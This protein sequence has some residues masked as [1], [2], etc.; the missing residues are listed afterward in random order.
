MLTLSSLCLISLL[1]TIVHGFS[2]LAT[3]LWGH[4]KLEVSYVMGLVS[5]EGRGGPP[6]APQNPDPFTVLSHVAEPS[7][8]PAVRPW[9]CPLDP[10][11]VVAY[12]ASV[13]CVHCCHSLS[14]K[15]K[16]DARFEWVSGSFANTVLLVLVT[17]LPLE[18]KLRLKLT[19]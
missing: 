10:D 18:G 5:E 2:P 14:T 12:H 11:V 19:R 4:K 17:L 16:V 1:S 15:S 3:F 13:V 6:R 9:M 8:L 7:S